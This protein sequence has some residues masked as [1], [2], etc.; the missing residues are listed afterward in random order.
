M[1]GVRAQCRQRTCA[2][3]ARV[4]HQGRSLAA[5]VAWLA[6]EEGGVSFPDGEAHAGDHKGWKAIG[7]V[8]RRTKREVLNGWPDAA[9][10]LRGLAAA[11]EALAGPAMGRTL[12]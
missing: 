3:S 1:A 12:P 10:G 11:L 9:E 5:L 8:A 2:P 4:R 6:C 7:I